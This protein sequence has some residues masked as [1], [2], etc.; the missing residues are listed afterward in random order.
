MKTASQ[1]PNMLMPF[2]HVRTQ[3]TKNGNTVFF[4]YPVTNAL[5]F[6]NSTLTY[7]LRVKQKGNDKG[8]NNGKLGTKVQTSAGAATTYVDVSNGG[9]S[10]DLNFHLNRMLSKSPDFLL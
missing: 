10:T 4:T 1:Q 2:D 8:L 5:D 9:V 7:T 3:Q 6:L